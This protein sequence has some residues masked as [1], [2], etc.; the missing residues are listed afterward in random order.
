MATDLFGPPASI[1]L[2]ACVDRELA[3]RRKH[4]PRWVASGKLTAVKAE[5]EIALMEAVR[6]RLV[7]SDSWRRRL[8]E[9]GV[10]I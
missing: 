4:Y 9:F 1:E 8:A 10:T 3:L 2:V 6:E 7:E 5:S